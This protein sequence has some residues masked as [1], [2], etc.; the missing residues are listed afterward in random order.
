MS[1]CFKPFALLTLTALAV[2][3]SAQDFDFRG[4]WGVRVGVSRFVDGDMKNYLGNDKIALGISPVRIAA[5]GDW[6]IS[7][8]LEFT[9]ANEN[10]NRAT[11]VPFTLGVTKRFG[12]NRESSPYIAFRGGLA[13]V[14]YAVTDKFMVRHSRRGVLPT[15]NAE[16]GI[17]FHER[18]KLAARYDWFPSTDGLKFDA[19]QLNLTIG[20]FKF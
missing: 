8:D 15:A 17:V 10:G 11:L 5:P 4:L 13:Y 2:V 1:R 14:D 19:V 7:T 3:S 12:E 20:L 6:K 9:F 16:V 18:V